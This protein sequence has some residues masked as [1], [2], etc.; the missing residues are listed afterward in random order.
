MVV[1]FSVEREMNEPILNSR[2]SFSQLII[3]LELCMSLKLISK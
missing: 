2:Q 1:L 3:P